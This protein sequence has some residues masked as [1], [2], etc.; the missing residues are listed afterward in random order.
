MPMIAVNM[1]QAIRKA[2]TRV[3]NPSPTRM[4]PKNSANAAAA[5]QSHAGRM[6][7][8][9]VLP[10]V[11]PLNPGPLK[12]PRTFCEPCAI[13]TAAS[14]RRTGTVN[15]VEEVAISL[16]NMTRPFHA[17]GLLA[18]PQDSNTAIDRIYKV[19]KMSSKQV[20]AKAFH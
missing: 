8:N 10:E 2:A 6:K 19:N 12:L 11:K 5:S 16:R 20:R 18:E 7:P 4:P 15:Q 9:G 17:I 14:A 1:T 13:K 3:R